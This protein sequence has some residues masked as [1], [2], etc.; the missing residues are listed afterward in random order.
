[1]LGER[2]GLRGRKG[3]GGG[4]S[5]GGR[6]AVEGMDWMVDECGWLEAREVRCTEEMLDN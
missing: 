2:D 3:D 4:G 5:V 1:M 6:E